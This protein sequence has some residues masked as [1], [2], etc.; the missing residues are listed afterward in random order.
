MKTTKLLFLLQ[1]AIFSKQEVIKLRDFVLT[2]SIKSNLEEYWK[3][4][5]NNKKDC[6]IDIN[7]EKRIIFLEGKKY[8]INEFRQI[9]KQI[10]IKPQKIKIEIKSG[11][12]TDEDNFALGFNYFGLYNRN[13]SIKSK[14]Q[15]FGFTG[16]G[17]IVYYYPEPLPDF[18]LPPI[19]PNQSTNINLAGDIP[20]NLSLS[21]AL[22]IIELPI[23][24]SGKN[25]NTER[26]DVNLVLFNTKQNISFL[27]TEEITVDNKKT[28]KIFNGTGFPLYTQEP[29]PMQDTIKL[30]FTTRY[31]P[32]GSFLHVTPKIAKNNDIILEIL[33]EDTVLT[34][35]SFPVFQNGI[36]QNPPILDIFRMFTTVQLK[37]NQSFILFDYYHS[38]I[39]DNNAR[40]P[41]L[42]KV[43]VI[44]KFFKLNAYER[45]KTR[46]FAII[47]PKIIED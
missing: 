21:S 41:F 31:K 29:N 18:G 19:S 37:K 33:I 2:D 22:S 15:N 3:K 39:Q 35:T 34:N 11:L 7:Q 38:D 10:D 40:V 8:H 30:I 13:N 20:L 25:I 32:I 43:P 6:V 14:G 5:T 42:H 36:I 4:I 44:G 16:M 28:G 45:S 24:F 9:I 26:L 47:T 23:I 12:Y 1:F 17:G 46:G 27:I